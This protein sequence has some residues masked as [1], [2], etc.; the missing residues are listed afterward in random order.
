[1]DSTDPDRVVRLAV[2]EAL[3]RVADEDSLGLGEGDAL[4][5]LGAALRVV[6]RRALDDRVPLATP[7]FVDH[8]RDL[9]LNRDAFDLLGHYLMTALLAHHV[10]PDALIR[11]GV[12]FGTVRRYLPGPRP[13][14]Y[15]NEGAGARR[16]AKGSR[17]SVD[18]RYRR[19]KLPEHLPSPPSWTC[20][21]C[22]R[23]WPCATKQSQLL[24]E[25]GG[26][27]AAL[28]VYLGSCLVAAAQDLP[29]VPLPRVR[30]RFLGWLPRARI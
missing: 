20:T 2:A 23:E 24:A 28:A 25:F 7:D 21:G 17:N 4:A 13:S 19:H 11:V 30:L 1:M 29:T 6:L 3:A 22:G 27:R 12:L 5:G 8:C 18:G 16:R 10:G 14:A 9:G 15:R 26:A